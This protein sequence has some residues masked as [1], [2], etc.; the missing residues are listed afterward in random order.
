MSPFGSRRVVP[1]GASGG[2]QSPIAVAGYF[3][4]AG[5][6]TGVFKYFQAEIKK[7]QGSSAILCRFLR[8]TIIKVYAET[9]AKYKRKK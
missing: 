8:H 6:S 5:L 3:I 7:R 1:A 4:P 2:S 9:G